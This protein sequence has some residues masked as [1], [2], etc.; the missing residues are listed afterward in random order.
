MLISSAQL[1]ALLGLT[2]RRVQ[3]LADEGII[4][5]VGRGRSKRYVL[6]DAVQALLARAAEDA[7][8]APA[9]GTIREQFEAER[10]RKLKLEND[11]AEALLIETP[12]AI[13][14][15]DGIFGEVRTALGGIAARFT[16]DLPER[17]RL[18]NEIDIVLGDLA[19]RLD[20]A[21][22]ALRKGGDPLD[23]DAAHAS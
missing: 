15:I 7:K 21:G 18:E 11:Q 13:A 22:A 3:Q 8:S 4:A 17:R 14:A 10:A 16:S 6:A 9:A 2:E 19:S 20:K 1:G 12:D 5:N 23:A